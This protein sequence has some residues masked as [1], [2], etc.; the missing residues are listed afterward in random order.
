[1]IQI[2]LV[3][4]ILL[5]PASSEAAYKIY[6]KNGSVISGVRSYEKKGGEVTVYFS[7]GSMAISEKD[8]LKIEGTE[9]PE[10]DLQTKEQEK[11]EKQ[12]RPE[13]AV[14]P[15]QAPV[16]DKSA[17]VNALMADLDA[18]NTEIRAVEAEE[19]RLVASINE[20]RGKKYYNVIQLRQIEK[21]TEPLQQELVSIQ[22][23]KA[24]LIQRKAS[25]EGELRAL[26]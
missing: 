17:R 24:D 12:E 1:M 6:L 15:S 7:G 14:V 23:K 25:I 3:I 5:L 19:A 8:I 2:L 20:K 22:Q 21:E 13:D 18:V 16:D 4:L 11:E 10:E 9:T 26:Q